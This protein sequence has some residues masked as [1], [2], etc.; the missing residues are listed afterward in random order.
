M[1][2]APASK[3]STKYEIL[4]KKGFPRH[5]LLVMDSNK[6]PLG[7]SHKAMAFVRLLFVF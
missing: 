5:Q 3:I 2:K 4:G 6:W 7:K 1:L